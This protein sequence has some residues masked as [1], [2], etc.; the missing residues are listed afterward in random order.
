[1]INIATVSKSELKRVEKNKIIKYLKNKY[2]FSTTAQ[3]H[4]EGTKVEVRPVMLSGLE[5]LRRDS[6]PMKMWR[7]SGRNQ[8]E[9][10]QRNSLLRCLEGKLER[11]D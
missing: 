7:F 4:D 11:P 3:I 1:M 10:H 2:I 9:E 6:R 8:G 5:T